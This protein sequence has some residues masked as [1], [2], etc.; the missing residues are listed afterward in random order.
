M[1]ITSGKQLAL[2]LLAFSLTAQAGLAQMQKDPEMYYRAPSSMHGKTVLLPIGTTLEGR[3]DTT[4][5]SSASKQGQRFSIQMATPILAN[6]TDVV[7]PAGSQIMGEV[8][9]A[10]PGSSLPHMKGYPKPTG[11]LRVQI[12]GLRTPDGVTYPMVASLAGETFAMGTRQQAN[13]HL[14]GGMGYIGSEAGFEAV[15]PGM[16]ERSR[17]SG[18]SGP[19]VVSRQDMQRDP[20]YG[21]DPMEKMQMSGN[22]RPTIRSLQ[23]R[24]HDIYIDDGSPVTVRLDAPFKIGVSAAPGAESNYMPIV[25]TGTEIG[26]SG[27]R[28]QPAPGAQ[29][30]PAASA[31]AA[32]QEQPFQLPTP[33]SSS[34]FPPA[35]PSQ[36]VIPPVTPVQ[37]GAPQQGSP[38]QSVLPPQS[39]IPAPNAAPAA[40][41]QAPSN[42][43]PAQAPGVTF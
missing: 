2:A 23:K 32:P 42:S 14:G 43:Q 4:I 17:R 27:R 13:Q 35:P 29:P 36:S 10:L 33:Q 34:I 38:A 40:P 30:A 3:I 8:V 31:P 25:D 12:S 15:A 20:L 28:F 21:V 41:P 16:T 5:G 37:G 9:E 6:G 11:K 39:A 26:N 24:G 1:H 7:I 19:K 22:Q 18:M